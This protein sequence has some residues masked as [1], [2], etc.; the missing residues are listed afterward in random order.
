MLMEGKEGG[1]EDRKAA[2]LVGEESGGKKGAW[3]E[4]RGQGKP[5]VPQSQQQS[6]PCASPERAIELVMRLSWWDMI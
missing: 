3:L 4:A 1:M 6:H 5:A 2:V